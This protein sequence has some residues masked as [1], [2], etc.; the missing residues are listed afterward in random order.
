MGSSGSG[1]FTDY[2]GTGDG[3]TSEDKCGAAFSVEL[4]EVDLCEFVQNQGSLPPDQTEVR[5][6][7]RVRITVVSTQ[8]GE[9]IGFLPT[10]YNFIATCLA[11]GWEYG[12][13]VIRTSSVP[14]SR[15]WVDIGPLNVGDE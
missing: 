5:V 3:P 15:V 12:G 10:K 6:E 2:P 14:F 11:N 1:S 8:T 9:S 13:F 7:A 4:E